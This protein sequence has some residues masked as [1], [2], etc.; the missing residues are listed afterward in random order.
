MIEIANNTERGV[1]AFQWICIEETVY[2]KGILGLP[3]PL[4]SQGKPTIS[5]P[6]QPG[7]TQSTNS[8]EKYFQDVVSY[9]SMRWFLIG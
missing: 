2:V 8:V 9:L 3:S 7:K 4:A 1:A 5:P 6:L